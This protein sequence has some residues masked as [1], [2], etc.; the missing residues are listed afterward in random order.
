MREQG[1]RGSTAAAEAMLPRYHVVLWTVAALTLVYLVLLPVN[2]DVINAI[3]W[4]DLEALQGHFP[5]NLTDVWLSR[6]VGYKLIIYLADD[7]SRFFA[8][9]DALRGRLHVFNAVFI[10]F[11]LALLACAYGAFLCGRQAAPGTLTLRDRAETL[12]LAALLFVPA[13][14]WS[15]AQ[16]TY[17]SVLLCVVGIG[18]VL[19]PSV[20]AQWSS[21]LVLVLLFSVKGVTA[22]DFLFV[23]MSAAATGDRQRIRRVLVSAAI[24]T[25]VVALAYATILHSELE[26]ILLAARY[27][28]TISWHQAVRAFVRSAIEFP[29]LNL[30][31]PIALLW[32]AVTLLRRPS[33]KNPRLIGFAVAVWLA[34]FPAIFVQHQFFIYHFQGL[35]L[36][37]WLCIA[38]LYLSWG[39]QWSDWFHMRLAS[40]AAKASVI[41]VC[42][43]DLVRMSMSLLPSIPLL[44]RAS[45]YSVAR[46]EQVLDC[47]IQLTRAERD[48]IL[49]VDP[50]IADYG[51]VL[52]LL[53]PPY[54]LGLRS[55]SRFFTPLPLY[56]DPTLAQAATRDYLREILTYDGPAVIWASPM[57][58]ALGRFPIAQHLRDAGYRPV[59]VATPCRT[60]EIYFRNKT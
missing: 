24:A 30:Q 29:L 55:A 11:A 10:L 44:P 20:Y 47:R 13:V 33:N 37:A 52:N 39:G 43:I 60:V 56:R 38:A 19:S 34:P 41:L 8:P 49:R 18:L 45:A 5:W 27:R 59:E 57:E 6:G 15:W 48:A 36:S 4:A 21:G 28:L 12:L 1:A 25:A 7:V 14:P 26:N 46:F 2:V 53:A 42:G 40:P 32:L 3:T 23:L 58:E 16:D 22:L 50:G 35:V 9:G 31:I 17:V 54:G 51:A